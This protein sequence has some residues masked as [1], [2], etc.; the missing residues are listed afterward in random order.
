MK[1]KILTGEAS[2]EAWNAEAAAFALLEMFCCFK[3]L[4]ESN[5]KARHASKPG[6]A[7]SPRPEHQ[8]FQFW[9]ITMLLVFF[10]GLVMF[11]S[12]SVACCGR[13]CPVMSDDTDKG[14][15]TSEGIFKS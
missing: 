10:S 1:K 14:L 2:N 9:T 3:S 8:Q 12:L 7:I 15:P 13:C 6:T 5:L 11:S 4:A